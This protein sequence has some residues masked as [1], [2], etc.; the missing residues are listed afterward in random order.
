M[1]EYNKKYRPNLVMRE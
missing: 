1:E